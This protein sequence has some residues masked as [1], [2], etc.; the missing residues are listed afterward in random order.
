MTIAETFQRKHPGSAA[1]YRE[2]VSL[3]PD[4]VTHDTRRFWPFPLYVDRAEGSRK[5]DV[6]GNEIID[7]V[8][9]HG[10]LFLG[11]N[12]P[13]ILAA[14]QQQLAKGTHYGASHELEVRWAAAVKELLPSIESLRFTSS[15]TEATHMAIRL[16]RAFT[17]R[18]KIVRFDRH[19]HGWHDNVVGT[20]G[21]ESTTPHSPGVPEATLSNVIVIPPNDLELLDSTLKEHRDIAAVIIEPTGGS[22][23]TYPLANGFVQGVR[24]VTSQNDVLMIMD[25]VITGFRLAPGGAQQK[26]GVHAD[27]TT[28]A[29]IL[30]GGLPGGA[31]GGRSDVLAYIET[32]DDDWNENHRIAHQGTFNANPL[33]A[34]A[35]STALTIVSDGELHKRADSLTR[36]WVQG[37][38]ALIR[39]HGVSGCAYGYSSKFHILLGRPCPEPIDDFEWPLHEGRR[40]MPSAMRPDLA[41]ALKQGLI[42]NG[43][44][45]MS[46]GGMLSIAHSEADIDK[47]LDAFEATISQMQDEGLL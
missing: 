25:E 11:H 35:G 5:W 40:E 29:K 42:N 47:S 16:A 3:F 4:G 46:T 31:V 8:V 22:W 38:N 10:A 17:G 7:Y 33:S 6:D 2:A 36:R 37:M 13:A 45:L 39:K 30:A 41:L 21:P 28:M 9:G 1:L 23:G 27:I 12:H 19:F 34:A 14:T 18:D 15:G 43:V 44:D 24:E 32:R 26:F 20:A